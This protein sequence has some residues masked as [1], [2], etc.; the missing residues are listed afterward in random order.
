MT[1]EAGPLPLPGQCFATTDQAARGSQVRL[2][3]SGPSLLIPL[4]MN[5]RWLLADHLETLAFVLTNP[6]SCRQFTL[7]DVRLLYLPLESP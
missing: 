7:K 2:T 6:E 1:R 3:A 5:P 4:G